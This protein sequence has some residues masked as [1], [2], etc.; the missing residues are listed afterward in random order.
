MIDRLSD[1]QWAEYD[2]KGYLRLGFVLDAAE[3]AV[4]RD[5]IDAIMLGQV[6]YPSLS[7]QLDTGGAYE[8]LPEPDARGAGATLKYRKLQGLEAD[9]LVRDIITR[10]LFRHIC[11]RH[12]G[13]HASV[14]IFR[15]MLMNK[16]A[17]QGTHLPWHQDGGDVWK[18]DRDPL[19]T[20][21]IALDPA[22]RQNGCVEV[23][24]GTHR[25]GLLTNEGSTLRPED[26]TR[27]CPEAAIEYLEIDAGECLL[28]HNWLLH[29][30]D[31]NR[32]DI[33]RRALSA[34]YMDGRTVSTLTGNHFPMVFGDEPPS[35]RAW[36]FVEQLATENQ[37]L[38]ESAAEAERYA[39]SLVEHAGNLEQMRKEA[40][41]YAKSLEA[42]LTRLR[43]VAN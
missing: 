15:A 21:W 1:Q 12:Y 9:P 16:P 4:L 23:V 40:E 19:V 24:P 41:Q 43:A 33:P 34:C 2:E 5:R 26:V 8:Q 7:Y 39:R 14:S 32:T 3:I 35:P 17:Q 6:R 22:T 25:L 11:G 18:L 27:H 37:R 20:T 13:D 30:S 36:T 42:E 31:I 38:R 29:R 28:L 10:P